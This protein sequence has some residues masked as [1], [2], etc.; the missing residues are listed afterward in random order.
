MSTHR[1]RRK[2]NNTRVAIVVLAFV[3]LFSALIAGVGAMFIRPPSIDGS[4]ATSNPPI[5]N[6][7]LLDQQAQ[8]AAQQAEQEAL[9]LQQTQATHMERKE[10][11]Y[12]ILVSGVDNGNG[13]SDTNILFGVDIA[14]GKIH[15]LSIPRDTKCNINGKNY[16]INAAYNIGGMELMSDS[17]GELLGVPVDFT[18][19]VSLDAFVALVDTIGGVTFDVPVNMNYDDPIQGLS[20]HFE[21]GIQ[22]LSGQEALE[23]VRYRHDTDGT[24]GYGSEDLGRM[25]TQ[26]AFLTA[27]AKQML[28]LS[29]LD[30]ISSFADIFQTHVDTDLTLGN[31]VWL[32][33]ETLEMGLESIS[34]ST[35]P[36]EWKSPYIYTDAQSALDVVNQS[37]NPYKEPRVLKDLQIPS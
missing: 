37:L 4:D 24:G 17:I 14:T 35:L 20:I 30:K 26:Q 12:T 22:Q 5:E 21:K 11:F 34:F 19:E 29:N 27:I 33:T 3:A 15:G 13:G 8:D 23:V 9:A 10:D 25:A 7:A 18:V 32:G 1:R 2:R 28:T 36:G 6:Q 16:K 31:L